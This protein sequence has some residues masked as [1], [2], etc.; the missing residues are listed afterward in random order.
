MLVALWACG[1]PVDIGTAPLPFRI[2]N[3][4]D[5]V[6]IRTAT[7]PVSLVGS[8]DGTT[9]GTM[10]V[11]DASDGFLTEVVDRVLYLTAQCPNGEAGCTAGFDLFLPPG[12]PVT[13]MTTDGDVLVDD[14][15]DHVIVASSESGDLRGA[16]LGRK[17]DLDMETTFGLFDVVFD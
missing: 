17:M 15:H 5:R 11:L 16:H 7:G 13:V 6:E 8:D 2:T 4:Y 3:P 10:I 9:H 1:A 14:L 12:P